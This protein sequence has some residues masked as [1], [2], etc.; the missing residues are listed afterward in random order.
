MNIKWC[1]KVNEKYAEATLEAAKSLLAKE[2]SNIFFKI[3]QNPQI[4]GKNEISSH[5]NFEKQ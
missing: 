3:T 1:R 5:F 2:K 4:F